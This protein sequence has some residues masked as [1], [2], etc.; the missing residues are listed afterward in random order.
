MGDTVEKVDGDFLRIVR[1]RRDDSGVIRLYGDLFVRNGKTQGQLPDVPNE[2]YWSYETT[3]GTEE[4]DETAN[5][6]MLCN[7][8][9]LRNLTMTSQ[10]TP[11]FAE[12]DSQSVIQESIVRDLATLICRWKYVT[13]RDVIGLRDGRGHKNAD[14]QWT[15][16]C[17]LALTAGEADTALTGNNDGRSAPVEDHPRQTRSSP[18]RKRSLE[19]LSLSGTYRAPSKRARGEQPS[20]WSIGAANLSTRGPLCTIRGALSNEFAD[21]ANCGPSRAS[22]VSQSTPAKCSSSAP[23]LYTFG[24]MYCGAGGMSRG[25]EQAGL[26]IIWGLD[27]DQNALSAYRRNF[28]AAFVYS[29]FDYEFLALPPQKFLNRKVDILHLSPPCQPFAEN[30]TTAGVHD[31]E[32]RA[33]LFRIKEMLLIIR[34]RVA[35]FENVPNLMKCEEHKPYFNNVL[36]SFT[37]LGYSVRWKVINCAEHGVAQLRKRLFIIASR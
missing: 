24:D 13:F 7:V 37:S 6:V 11:A 30:H 9:Q 29:M 15:E 14:I 35:T 18:K 19:A 17:I 22:S 4:V 33:C 32:N 3:N 8:K 31:E 36:G 34:P 16:R 27:K 1:I 21:A 5:S 12:S 20:G 23:G 28:P 10:T 26:S 25:A 2:V